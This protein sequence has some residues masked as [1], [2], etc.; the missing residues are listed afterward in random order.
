MKKY[1]HSGKPKIDLK[2]RMKE[3]EEPLTDEYY[4]IYEVADILKV[5]ERTI[6][7]NI[8]NGNLKAKKIGRSWRIKKEDLL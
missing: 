4:T 1:E 3:N 8:K 2:E 6:R 5:H 7:N